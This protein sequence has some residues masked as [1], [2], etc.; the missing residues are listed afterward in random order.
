MAA[1]EETG[2]LLAP[3]ARP[4]QETDVI[5]GR[6]SVAQPLRIQSTPEAHLCGNESWQDLEFK[7]PAKAGALSCRD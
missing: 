5:R 2:A 6:L 3:V 4:R 1:F 7:R